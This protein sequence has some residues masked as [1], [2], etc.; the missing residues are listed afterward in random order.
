[1]FE[2][3]RSSEWPLALFLRPLAYIPTSD[4]ILHG[5]FT[6]FSHQ[7]HPLECLRRLLFAISSKT[8]T[9][10]ALLDFVPKPTPHV[11]EPY[12]TS[13]CLIDADGPEIF[14]SAIEQAASDNPPSVFLGP[15][16]SSLV[17]LMAPV[18][19]V[20]QVPM[21]TYSATSPYLSSKGDYPSVWRTVA[22]D[23]LR[24]QAWVDIAVANQW[25]HVSVLVEPTLYS[26]GAAQIFQ[27]AAA[28]KG[29]SV[30]PF[31]LNSVNDVPRVMA[32]LRASKRKIVFAP[33]TEYLVEMLTE[34]RRTHMMGPPSF[35]TRDQD[36]PFHVAQKTPQTEKNFSTPLPPAPT[37]SSYLGRFENFTLP[38][39]V[40]SGDHRAQGYVWIFGDSIGTIMDSAFSDL[41]VG[42]LTVQDPVNPALEA[43]DKPAFASYLTS[44]KATVQLAY[45]AVNL[46]SPFRLA[47][48]ASESPDKIVDTRPKLDDALNVMYFATL[49]V[50]LARALTAVC[51]IAELN[52]RRYG[53]LP[54]ASNMTIGLRSY[55]REIFGES[56]SFDVQQDFTTAK[57]LLINAIPGTFM[58]EVGHWSKSGGVTM[59][60]G[61]QYP[62]S[63][64]PGISAE[65]PGKFVFAD[66]TTRVPDDG[67]ALESFIFVTSPLG[68]IFLIW[69]VLLV[70]AVLAT[71]CI[72]IKYWS[73]PIFRLASPVPLLMIL[74]GIIC[75]VL[76]VALCVGRPSS[77][78][79]T[80]RSLFYYLGLALIFS[81]LIT[82]T[83][84]VW[85][86]F[87]YANNFKSYTMSNLKLNLITLASL[88]PA[89]LIAVLRSIMMPS[90]DARVLLAKDNSRVDVVCYQASA[91][92]GLVQITW[93]GIQMLITCFLAWKTRSV[94]DGFN[95]TRHVFISAYFINTVGVLGLVTSTLLDYSNV[96]LSY[97]FY[98][99]SV[100]IVCSGTLTGLFLPKIRIAILQ[101]EKN[102]TDLLR[103]R[104]FSMI[105]LIEEDVSSRARESV[106]SYEPPTIDS[107]T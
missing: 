64:I 72:M 102:T 86:V 13:F 39:N 7:T 34:A 61:V 63:K 48:F 40:R 24:M 71:T 88:L 9:I 92:W 30:K 49:S 32:A 80:A 79:C 38:K 68:V 55:E 1:M 18:G 90:T 8:W 75:L 21:I 17:Q 27:L 19:D 67:I 26:R 10:Q 5:I 54:D 100:L 104:E 91:V 76:F 106:S 103:K 62:S 89:I 66:G 94:P 11:T 12:L 78:A 29:V 73:T 52:F 105:D 95:E 51:D 16:F 65:H 96:V 47:P 81:P 20:Y 57:L 37:S 69:S 83:F 42:V 33:C 44:A 82:K 56:V 35:K 36:T 3:L 77:A 4:H 31:T 2:F 43:Y 41:T 28:A 6:L 59:Q 84:R 107:D 15:E 22:S 23:T 58:N 97:A 46:S 101:P 99:F 98:G 85:M 87:R 53:K 93:A 60:S 14:Y 25:M 74:L 50:P 45:D 70:L